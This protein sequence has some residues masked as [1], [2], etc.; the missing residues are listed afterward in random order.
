MLEADRQKLPGNTE[1]GLRAS[2]EWADTRLGRAGTGILRSPNLGRRL[3]VEN[4]LF[5]DVLG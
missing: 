2:G 3:I 1:P 4:V 5:P